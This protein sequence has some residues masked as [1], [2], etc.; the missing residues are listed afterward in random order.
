M[1]VLIPGELDNSEFQQLILEGRYAVYKRQQGHVLKYTKWQY[2]LQLNNPNPL[3]ITEEP[4]LLCWGY[5]RT[6]RNIYPA[7]RLTPKTS[8]R[9]ALF[10]RGPILFWAAVIKADRDHKEKLIRE[11]KHKPLNL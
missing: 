4:A 3:A 5:A 1:T 8:F 6:Q 10:V 9:G 11:G 7:F 2:Q